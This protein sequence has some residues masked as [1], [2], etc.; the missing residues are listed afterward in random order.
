MLYHGGNR[1]AMSSSLK[2]TN[3]TYTSINMFIPIS[4]GTLKQYLHYK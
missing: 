1:C 3:L 4:Y 2:Y